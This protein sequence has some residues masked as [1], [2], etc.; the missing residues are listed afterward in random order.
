M[1]P[2]TIRAIAVLATLV[3]T[4]VS[5][6]A[7]AHEVIGNEDVP[8]TSTTWGIAPAPVDD[9][10][11]VSVRAELDPGEV[12]TDEVVVTN[13]SERAATFALHAS[14]GIVTETGD[15]DVLDPGQATSGGGSWVEIDP[16]VEIAAGESA[17]IPFT[18]RVPEDALPGDQPAG[19]TAAL[20]PADAAEAGVDVDAR[21]GVRLHLR[22]NGEVEAR[23]AVTALEIDYA[24]T[25]NPLGRGTV[26]V[27]WTVTNVGNVRLGSQQSV[28]VAGP[29]G[30]GTHVDRQRAAEQREILPGQSVT[31]SF[32]T[33]AWPTVFLGTT[34]TADAT[35]VGDDRL[36]VELSSDAATARALALPYA[37]AL[38]VLILLGGTVLVMRRRRR[39]RSE[40]ADLERQLAEARGEQQ[41]TAT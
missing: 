30:L 10:E 14:D 39:L 7:A 21:V 1:V 38:L 17:P 23:L 37:Q 2:T 3:V 34:L 5:A 11:R 16:E 40:R 13:Y 15:F 26:T 24:G 41:L 12:Y 29:W 6:G 33:E 32:E 36:D 20:V 19:I 27:G 18:V 25:W 9:D 22:V 35:V 28:D 31:G 4:G 8:D